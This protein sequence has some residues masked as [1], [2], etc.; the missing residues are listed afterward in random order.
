MARQGITEEQVIEAAEA[1]AASGQ[2]VTV[3]AVRESLGSGSYT[4][5][6]AHLGK[7]R[8]AGGTAATGGD[9]PDMPEGVGRAARV[10]W[11]TAWKAAQEGIQGEREA[12][13]AAR[14]DMA[15]E[16]Q[17]MA[18]EIARLEAETARQSEAAQQLKDALDT[19]EQARREAEAATHA[20][21]VENARLEERAKAA[22]GRAEGVQT[23][24]DKL[25]ERFQEL[26]AKVSAPAVARSRKKPEGKPSEP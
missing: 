8:A 26:A 19:A 20:L 14:R 7:W 16:R 15:R 21:Q 12:L 9:A 17:D 18:G 4:T 22:E 5:I 1:L 24:L 25:H 10:F 23:E 6:N 3:S 11:G 2:P 13:D